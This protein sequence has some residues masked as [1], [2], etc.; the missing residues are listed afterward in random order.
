MNAQLRLDIARELLRLA[1]PAQRGLR[2]M[3]LN[4]RTGRRTYWVQIP[5]P[6]PKT[7]E[8][9]K[10]KLT[11][12]QLGLSIEDLTVPDDFYL[13]GKTQRGTP[14]SV[15]CQDGGDIFFQVGESYHA[16]AV[17]GGDAIGALREMKRLM[18]EGM[19]SHPKGTVYRCTPY[20]NDEEKEKSKKGFYQKNGFGE[21]IGDELF[22]IKGD[23]DLHP[24]DRSY[25]KEIKKDVEGVVLDL[26]NDR[27]ERERI[28]YEIII[29]R[30]KRLSEN[31]D[32]TL[33]LIEDEPPN[34]ENI[35]K[36]HSFLK[37]YDF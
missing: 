9:K 31:E 27:D 15:N 29:D 28:M 18:K 35:S 16:G 8:K 37:Y 33:E 6:K 14:V 23:N 5:K 4:T 26:E 12:K 21:E 17:Q 13:E 10:E 7:I 1:S 34:I 3:I 11:A 22:A 2:R 30:R 19:E 32:R 20:D 36:L 25:L 24:I